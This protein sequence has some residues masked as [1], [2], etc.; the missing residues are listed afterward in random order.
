M[1]VKKT[2]SLTSRQQLI[3]LN[4]E[5]TNFDLTFTAKS[6]DNSHFDVLVVD[7]STLDNN[8]S[9][10]YK[11]AKGVIS[12]NIISD[13]NVYQNYFLCLKSEK[14]CDVEIIID[15]KKIHP[16]LEQSM[17]QQPMGQ[18]SMRQQQMGQ[19]S[20][21]QQPMGQQPMGQ[22]SF[23]STP[24]INPPSKP[25]NTNWKVIFIFIV[26]LGAIGVFYY[27]YNKKKQEKITVD[28]PNVA[29]ILSPP[30]LLSSMQTSSHFSS[31]NLA[32]R[33]AKLQI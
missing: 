31:S 1:S 6:L 8:P 7:Q 32:D 23:R 21:R 12:G 9:L 4:E 5:T 20:M 14:P 22:Q 24:S 30:S 19:Q 3:D 26:I 18:Q 28:N 13:K 25:S 15:K 27:M 16:R 29:S 11:R 10:E 33:I 2:L 17:G